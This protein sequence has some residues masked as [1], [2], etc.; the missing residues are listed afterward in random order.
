[1]IKNGVGN[2][3]V[4][5]LL[6]TFWYNNNMSKTI[7][8]IKE[9]NRIEGIHRDPTKQEIDT[10]HMFMDLEYLT[11]QDVE[12]FVNVYQPGAQL[13]DKYGMDVMIGYDLKLGCPEVRPALE[14]IIFRANGFKSDPNSKRK[15]EVPWFVHVDYE[16][17][18]PFMDGNGRSGRAIWAWMHGRRS[19]EYRRGFLHSF[20]YETL[21]YC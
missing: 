2:Y 14:Q 19:I 9:S 4:Y 15:E 13:R 5:F 16:R 7:K 8:F 18:H 12:N 6:I 17:L 11:I 20:Y 10:M 21:T 3:S 1:M